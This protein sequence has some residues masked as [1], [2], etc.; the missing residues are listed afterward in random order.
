MIGELELIKRIAKKVRNDSSVIAGI[1]DDA[2]VVKW[3]RD[4]YLL[5]ASDMTVQN[6]HFRLK[7][8][9]PFQ[10]GW[11]ALGRN[12]SDIAAMGGVPRYAL[13]SAA[14][15]RGLDAKFADALFDGINTMAKRFR[16]NIVGGDT[17]RAAAVAI[18]IALIGEVEKERLTM[19]SGSREGDLILVTG[20]IGE[21]P[22]GKHLDFVP[23]LA[24]ARDIVSRF[25]VNSMIDIS[26]SLSLD[27]WRILSASN[28]G[29]RIYENLIPVSGSAKSFER[30]ISSGE[31]FELLFTMQP[32]EANR[33]FRGRRAGSKTPVAVIGEIKKKSYGLRLVRGNG[34]EET[35]KPEGFLHF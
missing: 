16:I 20:E 35:L 4:K 6:V 32:R 30:A 11:K 15:S 19:R 7:K 33:Y 25:K 24:E 1:G 3:T 31:D 27:L 18:D 26:D 10:I 2:A 34:A 12:V 21:G 23:R 28:A 29:A 5:L 8:A 9:T 14:L 17:T 22:A 13:V